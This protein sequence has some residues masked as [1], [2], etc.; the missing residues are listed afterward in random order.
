MKMKRCSKCQEEKDILEFAYQKNSPDRL[1][2][3]CRKCKK[4]YYYSSHPKRREGSEE[5]RY[6]RYNITKD[7]Y[8]EM[9][10]A[11]N[12]KCFICETHHENLDI[13]HNHSTGQVRALLCGKCNRGLGLFE[14]N[15]SLIRKAASYLVDG[16][17]FFQKMRILK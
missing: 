5:E 1:S 3:W 10:E 12:G 15:P 14:D 9:Y 16:V 8:D 6:K 17:H 11:Q 13:D 2:R 7:E 4:Q